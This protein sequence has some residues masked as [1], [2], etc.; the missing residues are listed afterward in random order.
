MPIAYALAKH[1]H[2]VKMLSLSPDLDPVS[3]PFGGLIFRVHP[4]TAELLHKIRELLLRQGLPIRADALYEPNSLQYLDQVVAAQA[5][6]AA[7][8]D[9]FLVVALIFFLT[10]IPAYYI[11]T[12]RQKVGGEVPRLRTH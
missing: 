7:Y 12:P 1:G 8:R 3:V 5:N 11:R 2:G 6:A 9:G 10:M 4:A